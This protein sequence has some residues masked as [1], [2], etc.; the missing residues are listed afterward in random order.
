M[1]NRTIIPS[2]ISSAIRSRL[3]RSFVP[4][5]VALAC[6]ALLPS[7]QAAA[8]G[9]SKPDGDLGNGNTAEGSGALF[10]LT[11][12][13][14]NTADGLQALFNNTV[15]NYNTAVGSQA[16]S[17][18]TIGNQN[19]GAGLG[20]L[21]NNISGNNNSAIGMSALNSNTIGNN[22]IGV[23][24]LAGYNLTTGDFNIDIGNQGTAGEANTI[25]IGDTNQTATFV[26]GINGVPVAGV[27][28]VVD[29]HGQLGTIASSERFKNQIKPMNKASEA[30]FDLK[31]VTF[32]YKHEL[33]PK[34]LPQF[35]LVAEEV[36]K[37]DP[38]LVAHDA[39]GEV[40]TVRYEAVNAMLLNEFLKE[41]RRV[42]ELEAAVKE[43]QS[44]VAKQQKS[45]RKRTM[46]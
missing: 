45:S 43:L 33:D 27:A 25:R 16:L 7:A 2:V 17:F 22:N 40:Y 36:E 35:G 23:G 15:G 9:N 5:G 46:R 6:F 10:N 38:D 24:Y 20:A 28:V 39:A 21:H 1:F 29:G 26:A 30:I 12:G 42:E 32:R 8:G 14:Q 41:H 44:V 13:I 4:I 3:L 18:N 34:Q 31:P 11:I 37:V 19:T